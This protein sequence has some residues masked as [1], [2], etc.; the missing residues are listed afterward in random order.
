MQIDTNVGLARSLFA[1]PKNASH[2]CI[3]FRPKTKKMM[4]ISETCVVVN[5]S[6]TNRYDEMDGI[7]QTEFA[8]VSSDVGHPLYD[9][10]RR[11]LYFFIMEPSVR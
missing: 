10:P 4:H 6:S 3:E 7:S 2:H 8:L 1:D 5:G 11:K 9:V